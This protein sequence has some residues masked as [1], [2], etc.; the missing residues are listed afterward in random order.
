MSEFT[1]EALGR[2]AY[3]A[4]TASSPNAFLTPPWGSLGATRQKKWIVGAVAVRDALRGSSWLTEAQ[5]GE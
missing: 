4:S 1:D 2:I 3:E 5:A